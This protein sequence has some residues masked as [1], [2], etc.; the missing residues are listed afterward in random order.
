MIR[1][2]IGSFWCHQNISEGMHHTWGC[3]GWKLEVFFYGATKKQ[4]SKTCPEYGAGLS[5]VWIFLKKFQK[6]YVKTFCTV[7]AGLGENLK[8]FNGSAEKKCLKTCLE[9][10]A[11]LGEICNFLFGESKKEIRRRAAHLGLTWEKIHFLFW[12][13]KI[14]SKDMPHTC[15][16]RHDYFIGTWMFSRDHLAEKEERRPPFQHKVAS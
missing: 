7:G 5:E 3:L 9:H 15:T 6:K 16:S 1:V 10:G 12:H 11:N 2:N 8:L 14:L 13:A 4:H